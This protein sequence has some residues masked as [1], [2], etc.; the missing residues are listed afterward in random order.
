VCSRMNV[1]D[2]GYT[3]DGRRVC[4]GGQSL[5]WMLHVVFYETAEWRTVSVDL[6]PNSVIEKMYRRWDWKCDQVNNLRCLTKRSCLYARYDNC[7]AALSH[8]PTQANLIYVHNFLGET[9]RCAFPHLL[10]SVTAAA[11]A[12]AVTNYS[13]PIILQTTPNFR[14]VFNWLF[15]ALH[16]KIMVNIVGVAPR[17]CEPVP[18]M[19][20]HFCSFSTLQI[21]VWV[22]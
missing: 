18:K 2:P 5:L 17:V 21:T 13:S 15:M 11:A 20:T 1:V 14:E 22:T 7:T 16:I 8:P 3:S 10:S 9:Q 12:S 19:F 6:L 4:D